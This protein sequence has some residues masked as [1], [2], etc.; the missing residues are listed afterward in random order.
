MHHRHLILHIIPY[1]I[2]I[3]WTIVAPNIFFNRS[4]MRR[5]CAIKAFG[6]SILTALLFVHGWKKFW[7]NINGTSRSNLLFTFKTAN[8]LLEICAKFTPREENVFIRFT[9]YNFL[10]LV[11]CQKQLHLCGQ[12]VYLNTISKLILYFFL[13]LR[14]KRKTHLYTGTLRK[15]AN[16]AIGW[17][18]CVWGVRMS[19]TPKCHD[20]Y[21]YGIH[22]VNAYSSYVCILAKSLESIILLAL[23]LYGGMNTWLSYAKWN[24][25][26]DEAARIISSRETTRLSVSIFIYYLFCVVV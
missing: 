1:S 9:A 6:Q 3:R 13:P 25:R 14:W 18:T 8:D 11:V 5:M 4:P 19:I 10:D 24:M 21:Y 23:R 2:Y 7:T 12:Q 16:S 17:Q 15:L 20:T 22:M 26:C